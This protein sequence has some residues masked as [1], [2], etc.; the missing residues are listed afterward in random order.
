MKEIGIWTGFFCTI[1]HYLFFFDISEKLSFCKNLSF[2]KICGF[3]DQNCQFSCDL[4]ENILK[5]PV[6]RRVWNWVFGQKLSFWRFWQSWVFENLELSFFGFCKYKN[7]WSGRSV[8]VLTGGWL[9]WLEC[10]WVRLGLS[11]FGWR[12]LG[13]L[14]L[15]FF[16]CLSKN[17]IPPKVQNLDFLEKLISKSYKTQFLIW[18]FSDSRWK[19]QKYVKKSQVY[20]KT[21]KTRFE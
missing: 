3:C 19:I 8:K 7:A 18:K 10:G 1:S 11:V 20:S 9:P 14:C 21:P 2:L 12:W 4:A 5:N 16:A 6:F 15:A 17:L 13:L